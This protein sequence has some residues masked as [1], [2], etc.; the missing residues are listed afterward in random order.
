VDGKRLCYKCT[1]K[2]KNQKKGKGKDPAQTSK[3]GDLS[4]PAEQPEATPSK[5]KR[6]NDSPE[7]ASATPQKVDL[8][9]KYEEL[10][11]SVEEAKQ[12]SRT[13]STRLFEARMTIEDVKKQLGEQKARL[14]EK[15]VEVS[16]VHGQL[17]QNDAMYQ[18]KLD[19]LVAEHREQI[20]SLNVT[21]REL[22]QAAQ[23]RKAYT[24]GKPVIEDD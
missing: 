17:V 4:S 23:A 7:D 21:V 6:E 9:E 11:R 22:T 3:E 12:Q 1:L 14:A 13:L 2:V 16:R 8:S 18:R 5:R 19:D 10:Q 20:E 15:E 24:Y